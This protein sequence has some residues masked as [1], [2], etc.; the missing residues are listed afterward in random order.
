MSRA[1]T[2]FIALVL[3]IA[4]A[5]VWSSID[6][7][8][9]CLS[10]NEDEIIKD[11]ESRYAEYR[12][13]QSIGT[14]SLDAELAELFPTLQTEEGSCVQGCRE[15]CADTLQPFEGY[16]IYEDEEVHPVVY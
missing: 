3:G 6:V 2:G 11:K 12:R 15:L 4:I 10:T 13:V 14:A 8:N 7:S 1:A 5:Y 9:L 16:S